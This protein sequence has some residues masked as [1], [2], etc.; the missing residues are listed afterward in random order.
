MKRILVSVVSIMLIFTVI[1]VP[2]LAATLD[3]D[4][5]LVNS[6][7]QDDTIVDVY[8]VSSTQTWSCRAVS[9]GTGSGAFSSGFMEAGTNIGPTIYPIG[10]DMVDVSGLV[11]DYVL[12]FSLDF[13]V[14][15][16][17]T[18]GDKC[19]FSFVLFTYDS[20]LNRTAHS[21]RSFASDLDLVEDN[22][23][24]GVN[25]VVPDGVCYVQPAIDVSV[26]FVSGGSVVIDCDGF[27]IT[28]V[29][30]VPPPPGKLNPTDFIVDEVTN[31][32]TNTL[33]VDFPASAFS[34]P[35]WYILSGD[36]YDVLKKE[37]GLDISYFF[38]TAYGSR[39]WV[40]LAPTYND[41]I[42]I[43]DI[44]TGTTVIL[45]SDISHNNTFNSMGIRYQVY[46][47]DAYGES[48]GV[49]VMAE[50]AGD[51]NNG[52]YSFV[53]DK[54]DGAVYM[55]VIFQAMNVIPD[56][57]A[58]YTLTFNRLRFVCDIPTMVRVQQE[59][60]RTNELL[61]KIMNGWEPNPTLPPFHDS[62][63]D[64]F[65]KEDQI[66]DQLD[67]DQVQDDLG[68][69]HLTV[70]DQ[71]LLHANAFQ[72]IQLI[73]VAFLDVPVIGVIVYLSLLLGLLAAFLGM[74]V[75]AG[76]AFSRHSGGGRS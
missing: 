30:D 76:K 52:E 50:Q 27:K 24:V 47:F 40:D 15:I 1:V 4:D 26:T 57:S 69:M 38:D 64:S 74:G 39:Y 17:G 61:D 19:Y 59:T 66:I 9:P 35:R 34:S 58:T 63:Q 16:S 75:A 7:E 3:P 29:S 42:D 56:T 51:F 12:N 54:P 72:M 73:F 14:D 8:E 43:S 13:S 10:S 23:S 62:M 6:Y 41:M 32:D 48:L 45:D 46:Y 36:T 37:F 65:D 49:N 20:N 5:Y 71:I 55:A 31:G 53:L 21:L 67:P 11:N 2:A 28:R 22:F 33:Y 44:P 25:W 70:M 60:G 68:D 18:V